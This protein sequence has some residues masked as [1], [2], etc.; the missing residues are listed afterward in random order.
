VPPGIC[1]WLNKQVPD[2]PL[3]QLEKFAIDVI[4][5]RRHGK[6]AML[7]R[8]L[9]RMLEVVY[10]NV[11][12]LRC[13]CYEKRL[14]RWHSVGCLTISIGNLTVGGTGKTPI[15][16][17]FARTLTQEGRRV[18]ILS[19][20]YKSLAR[21]VAQRFWNRLA[22]RSNYIPPRVVSDGCSLLLDSGRAGDEPFMLASNLRDVVVIVD[23]DRVK[24]A[25][26]A[27]KHFN[28][29]TL[30]L[31]D[32]YQYLPLKERLNI[33]LVDRHAP[34][35]NEHVL[36][37]GT[38]REPHDHLRRADVIFITKCDGGD[39]TDLKKR[40]RK[41]NRHA[42]I[43]ECTHKTLYLQDLY[44]NEQQPLTF[45]QGRDI[46]VIS[47]IAVPESFEN[48]LR[49]L[50]ANLIYARSYADHHRYTDPEVSNAIARTRA[51]GGH[52]LVT[53]EKDAVRF[54][55]V[56]RHDLPVYFLRVEIQLINTAESLHDCLLRISGLRKRRFIR[57]AP[58][59]AVADF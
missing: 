10:G 16:E 29:D 28:V 1:P 38:L 42:E 5:E 41:Y 40:L 32:G 35:G 21:P 34:F 7:L 17:Q 51:R 26:Y 23:K 15:V 3:E 2:K 47:G 43:I 19:R 52:A 6:R 11:M 9:L 45:L 36:P 33:T 58:L 50:G 44:T 27:I 54:P 12:R 55:R 37:R 22:L 49:K 25:L 14:A 30:L 31:D 4:L 18:A 8:C 46:G 57:P 24:S 56:N 13:W 53:T 20:G 59:S 39:L 48:S